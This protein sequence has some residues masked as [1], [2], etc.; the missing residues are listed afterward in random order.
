VI[1]YGMRL[2]ILTVN[3]KVH[4]VFT[5]YADAEAN[6]CEH[7]YKTNNVNVLICESNKYYEHQSK[8]PTQALRDKSHKSNT[9]V[10]RRKK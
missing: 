4:G 5:C 8:I 3:Q 10:S 9:I 7:T 6:G 2:F 1:R